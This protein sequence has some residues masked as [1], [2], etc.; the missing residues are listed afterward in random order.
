VVEMSDTVTALQ[1]E[2][3][4]LRAELEQFRKHE[5]EDLARTKEM[6]EDLYTYQAQMRAKGAC[7]MCE[8][9][10]RIHVS[11]AC[12]RCNSSPETTEEEVARLRARVRDIEARWLASAEAAE[13]RH[14]DRCRRVAERTREVCAQ[15]V[16]CH[17]GGAE[18]QP[19]LDEVAERIRALDLDSILEAE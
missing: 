18:A 12:S 9:T 2:N 10:G 6:M 16:L 5:A 8:N 11:V 17:W 4:K 14:K 13:P 19:M 15:V 1:A 3:E 7:E